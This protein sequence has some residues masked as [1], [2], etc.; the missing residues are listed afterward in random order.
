MSEANTEL[1]DFNP[2]HFLSE[3]GLVWLSCLKKTKVEIKLL[4]DINILLM[5]EKGIRDQRWNVSFNR[6]TCGNN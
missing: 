6:Q 2:V 1:N 4:A 3:P 5:V